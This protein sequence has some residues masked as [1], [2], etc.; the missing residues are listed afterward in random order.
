M[1]AVDLFVALRRRWRV[2]AVI[3]AAVVAI[4]WITT[5]AS[6]TGDRAHRHL[7]GAP[8]DLHQRRQGAGPD[9]AADGV[10]PHRGPR[11]R[12]G[13]QRP[14]RARSRDQRGE[15]KGRRRSRDHRDHDRGGQAA[16]GLAALDVTGTDKKALVARDVVDR[17]AVEIGV[18]ETQQISNDYNSTS[19]RLAK[20][21]D[22][23]NHQIQDADNALAVCGKD[24]ACVIRTRATIRDLSV[25]ADDVHKQ[26]NKA[27]QP[28]ARS[29]LTF[30]P[31]EVNAA[32]QPNATLTRKVH[33]GSSTIP[34]STKPRLALG[35]IVGMLLGALIA[36]LVGKLDSSV[37]G[38]QSTETSGRLP[39][40]AEIPH[41]STSRRRRF[42]VLTQ[43]SP[44]SGVAD[45][46]RG[47]RTS[48]GLMWLANES[49]TGRTEPRTLI[50]ASPGPN[51][52]KSTTRRE[53]RGGLRRDGQSGDRRRPRLP[54][55]ASPQV[56]RR[57]R[58]SAPRQHRHAVGA[59]RRPRLDHAVHEHSWRAVHRLGRAR[60]DAGRSRG[61]GT[62]GDPRRPGVVRHRHHRH[63]A[64]APHQRHVRPPRLRRRRAPA[65]ARRSHQDHGARPGLAA[66][67]P[68]R[69]TGARYRT[70]RRGEQPSWLRLWLRIRVPLRLLVR[71]LRLRLR[72]AHEPRQGRCQR[73]RPAERP[74]RRGVRARSGDAQRHPG[75]VDAPLRRAPSVEASEAVVD[76]TEPPA[77][78]LDRT[79][80]DRTTDD[81]TTS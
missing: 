13:R 35:L 36:F 23:L 79:T 3:V 58:G 63:A 28:R 17:L 11:P 12:N 43:L 6:K 48:I 1:N 73:R 10:V 26:L 56:P 55:P 32:G 37:Y 20:Q 77:P 81:E 30:R 68:P 57:Q 25:S 31:N 72:H 71:R 54:P 75:P 78:P 74:Q 60:L 24:R 40:L 38:V 67:A 21:Y 44:L 39:V 8:D 29:N 47:L 33:S 16:S 80:A 62:S 51:E 18:Y 45:A 61:G 4:A 46:Y 7:A 15:R 50:V 69:R 27:A 59:A 49:E 22:G 42:E 52:G 5:P 65:R 14:G 76:L 41:V 34:V 70:H 53:P 2:I 19:P 66:A 9:A 64:V